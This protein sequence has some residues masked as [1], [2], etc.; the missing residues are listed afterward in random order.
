MSG[1]PKRKRATAAKPDAAPEPKP[2]ETV[3]LLRTCK[4]DGTS[5]GDFKWPLTPG[6]RVEAPDWDPTPECGHGLHGLLNGEGD[7]ALLDWSIDARAMLIEADRSLVV[8]IGGKVKVPSAVVKTIGAL[9]K[10]LCSLVCDAKRIGEFI[11]GVKGSSDRVQAASGDGSQL[12]A[13]GYGSK[14]AAS[15]DGSK[16]AASGYRSQ[17]AA[18]GDGSVA[19]CAGPGSF[20]SAGPNGVIAIAWHDGQR[21]RIAVGYVGEGGIEAGRLYDVVEGKLT[22]VQP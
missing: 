14:L 13:S 12:A 3:I 11:A 17:L 19:M 6:A 22:P 10:L 21:P 4:A 20:A 5:H 18:S 7:W 16:L 15:G 9:P 8:E 1:K 2:P